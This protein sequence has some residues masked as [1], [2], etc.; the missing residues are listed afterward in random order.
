MEIKHQIPTIFAAELLY[1]VYPAQPRWDQVNG[2]RINRS[3]HSSHKLLRKSTV[4]GY[5]WLQ[6]LTVTTAHEIPT[7][8]GSILGIN[9]L[10]H[11]VIFS[12]GFC[13][14]I[15]SRCSCFYYLVL[16][17]SWVPR[18][19]AFPCASYLP[20]S[21]LALLPINLRSYLEPNHQL[22]STS[23]TFHQPILSYLHHCFQQ[24]Y[25]SYPS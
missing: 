19:L 21:T 8:Q 24:K 14:G 18:C 13:L 6:V 16:W 3:I 20:A 2:C 23:I 9:I 5:Q 22:S 17:I 1:Q 7:F 25:C 12:A 15:W 11:I 4:V 10:S